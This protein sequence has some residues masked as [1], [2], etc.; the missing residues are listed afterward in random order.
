MALFLGITLMA[1]PQEGMALMALLQEGMALM[2]VM[3]LMPLLLGVDQK[4]STL[5]NLTLKS[6]VFQETHFFYIELKI[7]LIRNIL[8]IDFENIAF[9]II[10]L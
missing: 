1:L 8:N 9:C 6:G 2:A 4:F 10:Y 7:I 3:L 5:S